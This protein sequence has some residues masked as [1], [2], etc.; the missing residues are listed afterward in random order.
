MSRSRSVLRFASLALVL[1]LGLGATG[2]AGRALPLPVAGSNDLA[3]GI[4][5][6]PHVETPTKLVSTFPHDDARTALAAASRGLKACRTGD[7]PIAID[8]TVEFGPSGKVQK[9]K[10]APGEGP[11]ADCVRADL[12]QVEIPGFEGPPVAMQVKVTL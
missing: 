7:A 11:V 9:M 8:A 2:C 6:E 4:S 3:V 5:G 1:H 10:V 12:R